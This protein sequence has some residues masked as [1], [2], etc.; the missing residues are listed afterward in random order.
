M[1][2]SKIR[3][4]T[5]LNGKALHCWLNDVS[6]QTLTNDELQRSVERADAV[7]KIRTD[8]L[9]AATIWYKRGEE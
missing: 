1:F 4:A 9:H 5:K 7:N 2:V 6:Y 8:V 3:E